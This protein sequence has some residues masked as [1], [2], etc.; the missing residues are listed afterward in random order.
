MCQYDATINLTQFPSN[1]QGKMQ[2]CPF[3]RSDTESAGGVFAFAR[4]IIP[5][6]IP[7]APFS[8]QYLSLPLT[9]QRA[10]ISLLR[11]G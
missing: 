8:A 1:F 2:Y 3:K 5:A 9:T 6:V 4:R 11:T 7:L 10:G